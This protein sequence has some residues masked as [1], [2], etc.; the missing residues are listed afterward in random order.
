MAADDAQH[1]DA[2]RWF[3]DA[4]A[5]PFEERQVTV[6]GCAIHYLR[7]GDAAK[8]GV[9]LVHGG[10]A[11]A[12]WWSF[13]A[14]QLMRQYHV[15]ALDL[16]GHGDSGRREEYPREIWADEVMA[17][18]ADAGIAGPPVLVGHSLGGLVS[19]VA[20]SVYGD[21]LAGAIIVDSPVR[22]PDPESEEGARGRMFRNP[23]TYPD[24]ATALEHFRLMPPQPC[25]NEFVLRHV[26]RH[27]L[28]RVAAGWTWKFDPRVFIRF[29][30]K[31]MSDYLA[32]TRCRIAV[33]RGEFSPLVPPETGAYMY[34]LLNRNAPIVEIPQ[35]YH[36][37][38]L[39]Q[40]LAF[41]AAVRA[42]L[43][44]WEH[45]EPRRRG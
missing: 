24:V 22:A 10:A 44:D 4:L 17:V 26:A 5:A 45:S 33:L 19:I 9:V 43:A 3:Q 28:H 31:P 6:A 13:L 25:A 7:W 27:S 12:H 23:K 18:T 39:D 8:P 37:L 34:E 35:A 40:P 41:I 32:A 21:R 36:H 16:S 38:I 2:P 15:V 1:P 29:S 14:P 20:A 30:L 11:H 42:L